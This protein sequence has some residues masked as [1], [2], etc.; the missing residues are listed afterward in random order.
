MNIFFVDA[1]PVLAAQALCDKHVVK[2]TLESA[3]LL[4]TAQHILA[5][6]EREIPNGIY[7]PT[8]K[9]HPCAIWVRENSAN[10]G[11]L[12]EHAE[13]LARE[14]FRRYKRQHASSFIIR[15]ALYLRPFLELTPSITPPALCMPEQYK[16]DDPVESYRNYYRGEKARIAKW[17]YSEVPTWFNN[18]GE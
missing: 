3:Q 11:W 6:D 12:L 18:T 5:N 13:E 16:V 14:H 17:N 2:M 9:N 15:S 4:S 7:K 8:H 10:Y 1:D